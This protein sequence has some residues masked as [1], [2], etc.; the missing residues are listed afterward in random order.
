ML[1]SPVPTALRCIMKRCMTTANNPATTSSMENHKM[2]AP[3]FGEIT[4]SGMP[5]LNSPMTAISIFV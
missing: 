5:K 3:N 2:V 4:T 1:V